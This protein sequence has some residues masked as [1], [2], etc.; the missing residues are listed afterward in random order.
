VAELTCAEVGGSMGGRYRAFRMRAGLAMGSP[1]QHRRQ[2]RVAVAPAGF[3]VD[4]SDP[5]HFG[6][7]EYG[8]SA[9]AYA[10]LGVHVV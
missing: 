8:L 6:G 5:S 1:Q 2:A 10:E 9:I 3:G 7:T 4:G